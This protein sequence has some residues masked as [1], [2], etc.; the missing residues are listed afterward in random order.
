MSFMAREE[1][2]DST[3]TEPQTRLKCRREKGLTWPGG[4][5]YHGLIVQPFYLGRLGFMEQR[6]AVFALVVLVTCASSLVLFAQSKDDK[7][8]D[9]AQKKEIQNIVKIVDDVAAGQP[10]ANDLSLA[11]VR[12]D[13]LKAQGNKEYVPFTVHDRPVE[14]QR[15]HRRVLLARRVEDRRAAPAPEPGKK[16]DKK[17]K[18]NDK[19][20]RATTPTRTSPSCR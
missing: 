15:R 18:D 2:N 1:A 11:W 4:D 19:G 3:A 5:A 6:R 13:V 7:K 16:D 8:K 14:G 20:A 17:D 10:A 9:E 12:E